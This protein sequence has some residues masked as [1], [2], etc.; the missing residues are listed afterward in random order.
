[1]SAY[2]NEFLG[3]ITKTQMARILTETYALARNLDLDDAYN[4][5]EIAFSGEQ[6]LRGFQSGIFGGITRL[7][8]DENIEK[9]IQ[10]AVKRV[11]RRKKFRALRIPRKDEGG[12]AAL[13]IKIEMQ[14]GFST[15]EAMGMLDTPEGAALLQRGYE[16]LGH[17]IAKILV[18]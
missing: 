16:V 9:L 5:L 17:E 10:R 1:M 14:A 11:G 12:W 6:L 8:P 13:M 18:D 4:R 7:R 3:L 2:S 15:G